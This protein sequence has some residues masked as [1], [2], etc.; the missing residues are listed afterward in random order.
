MAFVSSPPLRFLLSFPLG[1]RFH[2]FTVCFLS[3]SVLLLTG[4]VVFSPHPILVRGFVRG[5]FLPHSALFFARVFLLQTDDKYVIFVGLPIS[6]SFLKLLF[7][8]FSPASFSFPRLRL[9]ESL[10]LVSPSSFW[11]RALGKRP[12]RDRTFFSFPQFCLRFRPN[13]G[14]RAL[15]HHRLLVLSFS[16]CA[17][18][19]PFRHPGAALF[20]KK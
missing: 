8:V 19:L 3:A 6:L 10:P 15:V 2:S 11:S 7:E 12:S 13:A 9:I 1:L 4:A 17:P 20:F 5:I 14:L 18:A 16:R